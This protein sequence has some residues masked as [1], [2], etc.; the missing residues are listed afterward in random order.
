MLSSLVACLSKISFLKS[1]YVTHEHEG[2][3]IPNGAY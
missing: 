3:G 2:L 1:E